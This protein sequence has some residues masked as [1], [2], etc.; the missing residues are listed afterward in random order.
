MKQDRL[1][2]GASVLG[3]AV[4]GVL[5]D[6]IDAGAVVGALLANAVVDVGFAVVAAVAEFADAGGC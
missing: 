1:A 6:T 3:I 2:L 4:A 5:V